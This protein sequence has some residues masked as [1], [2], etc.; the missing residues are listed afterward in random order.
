MTV[1]SSNTPLSA[2]SVLKAGAFLLIGLWIGKT[3]VN[4]NDTLGQICLTLM[5]AFQLYVPYWMYQRAGLN[6]ETEGLNVHGLILG[7]IAAFRKIMINAQREKRFWRFL[8]IK[9]LR[10]WFAYHGRHAALK[11]KPLL[12]DLKSV[13]LLVCLTFPPFAIG[14]HFFQI[15]IGGHTQ[16]YSFQLPPDM[17]VFVVFQVL[18]VAL[19]EELFYRGFMLVCLEKSWPNRAFIL[20]IP[21]GRAVIVSSIFFAFAHFVGEY[22]VLRLGPFFP[23]FLF[24]YLMLR[25]Q[26]I[27]GCL[28]YHALSNIFSQILFVGYQVN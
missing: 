9:P 20:G 15:H 10:Q 11:P 24:A 26:S 12:Q 1:S 5:I 27:F 22:N 23:A 16:G 7:P 13:C 18:L 19:P 6:P 28:T 2:N 17:L 4:I 25:S 21:I 8:Y 14:H 3:L